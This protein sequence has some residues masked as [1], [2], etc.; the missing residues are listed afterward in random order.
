[1][2]LTR[3]SY[4]VLPPS[5]SRTA[6]WTVRTPITLFGVEQLVDDAGEKGTSG[7]QLKANCSPAATSCGAA[8]SALIRLRPN[9]S[10]A[11][12]VAGATRVAVGATLTMA[13]GALAKDT[14]PGLSVARTDTLA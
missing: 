14:R 13:T 6:P 2:T 11:L 12:T 8:S 7:G 9:E 4:A 3:A 5:L 10:P 1:M